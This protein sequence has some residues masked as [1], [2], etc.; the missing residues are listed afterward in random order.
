MG[1][2]PLTFEQQ[3]IILPNFV[4]EC[5]IVRDSKY[6]NIHLCLLL[7]SR[8]VQSSQRVQQEWHVYWIKSSVSLN[9]EGK[10]MIAIVKDCRLYVATYH[11][12]FALS[13]NPYIVTRT[14]EVARAK[15]LSQVFPSTTNSH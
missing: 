5:R 15:L 8:I 9:G 7:N 3:G 1:E 10:K 6:C 13:S 14:L 4:F 2:K 12:C 11:L